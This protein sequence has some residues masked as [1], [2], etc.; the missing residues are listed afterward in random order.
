MNFSEREHSTKI[1]CWDSDGLRNTKKLDI[2]CLYTYRLKHINIKKKQTKTFASIRIAN[3][4]RTPPLNPI[5]QLTN[6]T[7]F[8]H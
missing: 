1:N 7:V 3:F 4:P 6:T 2:Y 8:S 5:R